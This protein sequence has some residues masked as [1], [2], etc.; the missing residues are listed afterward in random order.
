MYCKL[1][2]SRILWDGARLRGAPRGRVGVR[3]FSSSCGVGWGGVEMGQNKTMRDGGQRPH[4]LAPPHPAPLPSLGA[5]NATSPVVGLATFN[6]YW[7]W[8]AIGDGVLI[9]EA[10]IPMTV[11]YCPITKDIVLTTSTRGLITNAAILTIDANIL[12]TRDTVS[13]TST[14]DSITKV[15]ILATVA[16]SLVTKDIALIASFSGSIARTTAPIADSSSLVTWPPII[17][18]LVVSHQFWWFS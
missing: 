2:K 12:V 7:W 9:T 3:K 14:G 15:Y 1:T 17:M 6:N 13:T 8:L 10:S 5:N 4:P 11:A 16:S 18:A